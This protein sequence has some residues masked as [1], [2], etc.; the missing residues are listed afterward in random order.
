LVVCDADPELRMAVLVPVHAGPF[1]FF[2][3]TPRP[4]DVSVSA[5]RHGGLRLSLLSSDRLLGLAGILLITPVGFN[6]GKVSGKRGL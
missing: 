5:A 3:W 6:T 4:E 2:E 1:P